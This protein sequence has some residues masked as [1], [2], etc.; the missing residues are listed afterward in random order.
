V[1]FDPAKDESWEAAFDR[2]Y[3]SLWAD[4]LY[5]KIRRMVYSVI[6]RK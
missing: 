3:C 6:N 5:Q 2:S 1:R 4:R